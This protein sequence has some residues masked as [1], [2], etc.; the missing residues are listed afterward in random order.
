M[1]LT[2]RKFLIGTALTLVGTSCSDDKPKITNIGPAAPTTTT[3]RRTAPI[4]PST[5]TVPVSF[6]GAQL[7]EGIGA[8]QEG[9]EV[10]FVIK[11]LNAQDSTWSVAVKGNI[12][13]ATKIPIDAEIV[14]FPDG[15]IALKN[16]TGIL[17]YGDAVRD[18]ILLGNGASV[19]RSDLNVEYKASRRI[20]VD[21]NPEFTTYLIDGNAKLRLPNGNDNLRIARAYMNQNRQILDVDIA[22]QDPANFIQGIGLDDANG[23]VT[24][25]TTG[26]LVLLN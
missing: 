1:S 20:I 10:D 3:G 8:L 16:P 5:P 6:E 2:R 13:V 14:V 18:S 12:P 11:T 9:A 4:S 22:N 23:K 26:N 7:I 24:I 17:G 21:S 25:V 15:S 19:T